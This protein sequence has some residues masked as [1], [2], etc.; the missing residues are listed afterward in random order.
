MLQVQEAKP[1]APTQKA[2]LEKQNKNDN[3][4]S[5]C[6]EEDVWSINVVSSMLMWASCH[7]NP[8]SINDKGTAYALSLICPLYYTP[9]TITEMLLNDLGCLAVQIVS[10]VQVQHMSMTYHSYIIDEPAL[11]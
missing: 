9:E 3:L 10:L 11:H 5:E 6:F 8:W 4:P 1:L 2:K 7:R